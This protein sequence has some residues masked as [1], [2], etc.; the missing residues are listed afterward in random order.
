MCDEIVERLPEQVYISVDIDGLDPSLCPGTGTPVP[1]GLDFG[2][3]QTLL[4][5]V[6]ERGR[7]VV[8]FDLV[9][10]APRPGDEWDGNVGARVLYRLCGVAL[11]SQGARDTQEAESA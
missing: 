5:R 6:T 10:V 3:L 4:E 8:G 11:H 2:Q 7:R 9:E 1:G